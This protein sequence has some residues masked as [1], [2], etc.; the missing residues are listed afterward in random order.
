MVKIDVDVKQ[1]T[2]RR[3]F[4]LGNYETLDIEFVASVNEGDNFRDVALRLDAET[5]KFMRAREE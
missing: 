2:V 3:K 1:V 4:N 5:E